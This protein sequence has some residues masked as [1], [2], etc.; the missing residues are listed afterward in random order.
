MPRYVAFL[1]GINLGKRRLPMIRL[2]LAFEEIGFD[3]VE[4]FI[5]S[6]NVI[7]TSKK[8]PATIEVAVERHLKHSLGY[9][10]ETFVRSAGRVAEIGDRAPVRRSE[11]TEG[12]DDG[13]LHVGFFKTPLPT[14]L[15][16]RM[17]EI[18]TEV[19]HFVVSGSEYFWHSQVGVSQSKVW[20]LPEIRAVK[21]PTSTMRNITSIRKLITRHLL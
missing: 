10:V 6:G 11:P 20:A 1:R 18:R 8:A 7:F 2:K 16:D 21:L 9:P 13:T 15:A 3:Q 19:D 14:E 12:A 5:A 4:T 17:N